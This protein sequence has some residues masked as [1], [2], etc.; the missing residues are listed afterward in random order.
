M[1]KD[2]TLG[3][4]FPG[5]TALHRLDP[6]TKTILV[7][8]YIVALFL[9]VSYVSYAVLLAAL[10]AVIAVSKVRLKVLLKSLN[11]E[12][13]VE[14]LAN[15]TKVEVYTAEGM[16]VGSTTV[17]DGSASLQTSLAPGTVVIVRMGN[18]SVKMVVK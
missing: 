4:Y 5:D 1:L 10:A 16:L 8:A 14:G 11:G 17:V 6:R 12:I 2:I 9:A 18:K 13:S 7:I 3:Q 15:G